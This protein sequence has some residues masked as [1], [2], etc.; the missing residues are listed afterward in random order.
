[1]VAKKKKE[2]AL[3]WRKQLTKHVKEGKAPKEKPLAGNFI[4]ANGGKMVFS[5]GGAKLGDVIECVVI[6]WRFE[7]SWHDYGYVAGEPY[8]PTC[9]SVGVDEDEMQS[10][11][12]SPDRQ[13]GANH[14]C[15]DCELNEWGSGIGK[16]KACG[17]RRRLALVVDADKGKPEIKMLSIPPTSLANWKKFME[18]V[19]NLELHTMQVAL[20]IGFDKDSTAKQAPLTFEFIDEIGDDRVLSELAGV[21]D[22]ADKL[23]DEPN[24]VSGYI[25]NGGNKKVASKKGSKKKGGKKVVSKKGKSKFSR[26]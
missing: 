4:S 2:I 11:E 16:G 10:H 3:D 23:L 22:A 5:I 18:S 17:N 1:M 19:N 21:L 20:R 9:F 15:I 26:Q 7:N 14:G 12:T 13:G 24:D 8:P 6:G 25:G